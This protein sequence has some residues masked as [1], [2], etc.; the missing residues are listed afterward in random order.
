MFSRLKTKASLDFDSLSL[1]SLEDVAL[2]SSNKILKRTG[3]LVIL[4][5]STTEDLSYWLIVQLE[6]F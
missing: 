1:V 3:I 6:G 2:L 5:T 4:K